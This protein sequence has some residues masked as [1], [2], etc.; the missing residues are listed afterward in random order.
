M[1][2]V[3][4]YSEHREILD[5]LITSGKVASIAGGT[6]TGPFKEQRDAYVFAVSIAMAMG[7]PTKTDKMPTSK[8]GNTVIRDSVFL[9]AAG[10]N[11]ISL[12]VA[13][14]NEGDHDSIEKTLDCQ[15]KLISE[16]RLE[17]RFS[18]LD[19]FA[20]AGFTWL[21]NKSDDESSVRDLIMTAINEIDRYKSDASAIE[22]VKDPLLDMLDMQL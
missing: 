4:I 15:L 6:K 16:D 1:A 5:A 17:D 14:T 18:L 20:H 3:T 11:Q 12:A 9:G 13:L 8:K 2:N 7:K 19:R 21:K 10:A 22:T